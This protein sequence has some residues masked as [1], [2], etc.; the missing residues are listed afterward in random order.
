V[1]GVGGLK[2]E[3][4]GDSFL[5]VSLQHE[6]LVLDSGIISTIDIFNPNPIDCFNLF[7]FI[8]FNIISIPQLCDT[9]GIKQI[10]S[11]KGNA[12]QRYMT[13]HCRQSS[14]YH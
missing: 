1:W 3:E 7:Q 12:Q 4:W 11:V 6:G 13:L 2:Q 9:W 14:L 5:W 8:Y 10:A